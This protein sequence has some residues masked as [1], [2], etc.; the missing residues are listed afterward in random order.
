[1]TTDVKPAEAL[2]DTVR[3][4]AREVSGTWWWFLILGAL[5]TWFGMFIL[6]YRVASLAAV[7]SLV[8][9]AFLFGGVAQLVVASQV[10]SRRWLFVI[11]GILG[12]GVRRSSP[13]RR[14]RSRRPPPPMCPA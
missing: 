4:G 5:W 9:V 10:P 14:H 2:R 6:S 12:V 7:A 13:I 11:S 1:M 8:G 3:N